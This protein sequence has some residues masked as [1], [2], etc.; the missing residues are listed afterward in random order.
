MSY[1]ESNLNHT[2][3]SDNNEN[4]MLNDNVPNPCQDNGRALRPHY[5]VCPQG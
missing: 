5:Q 1:I 2:E 4:F 3:I